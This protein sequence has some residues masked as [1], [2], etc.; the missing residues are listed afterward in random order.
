[1]SFFGKLGFTRREKVTICILCLTILA[2]SF[3]KNH[4]QDLISANSDVLTH[5]DSLK[6]QNLESY[7]GKIPKK[8]EQKLQK[9]TEKQEYNNQFPVNINSATAE[10]LI[11]LP[12]IGLVLAEN[13]VEYRNTHGEFTAIDSILNVPGIGNKRLELIKDK[14]TISKTISEE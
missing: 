6:I 10:E 3:I 8:S 12:G 2:G 1:M 7:S 11:I 14:I 5:E 9:T 13:I 4:R